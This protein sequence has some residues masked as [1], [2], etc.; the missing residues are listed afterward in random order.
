MCTPGH[1]VMTSTVFDVYASTAQ[2]HLMDIP[3]NARGQRLDILTHYHASHMPIY[4]PV[5]KTFASEL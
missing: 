5:D 3:T 1:D 2:W 4:Q